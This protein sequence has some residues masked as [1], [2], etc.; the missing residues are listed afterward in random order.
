MFQKPEPRAK[1][2]RRE[3]RV[4]AK[5][6][7]VARAEAHDRDGY[8]RLY[9]LDA[10]WR[11]ELQRMFGACN[12]PSE[13]A[14]LGDSRRFRTRGQDPEVRHSA[15]G[16]IMLCAGHHRTGVYAYDRHTLRIDELTDRR[17]NG[18]LRFLTRDNTWE[19]S[20]R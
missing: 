16:G 8:C 11:A 4:E 15:S 19:E 5:A 9:V 1:Q 20:T 12:G 10:G 3:R 6:L 17:A 18:P 13:F 2:R 14:H 7:E